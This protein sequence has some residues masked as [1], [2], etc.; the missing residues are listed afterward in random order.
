MFYQCVKCKKIWQYPIEKCPDCFLELVKMPS[1]EI[2]VIGISKVSIPTFFHQKVPYF[3]LLLEDK[4]GNRWVQKSMKEYQID[5]DFTVKKAK[6]SD[7]VALFRV[8]YDIQE[9]IEKVL[10]SVEGIKINSETKILILPTLVKSAHPYQAFNTNPQFLDG[11]LQVL[12]ARGAAS[13]NIRVAGQGFENLPIEVLAKKSKMLEVCLYNKISVL[14]LEKT[15][16]KRV[17][18]DHFIFDISE[19]VFNND[20]IIN[21]P[22]L[23]LD[24][25]IGVRGAMENM[26]RFLK[27]ESFFGL[28]YLYG[29]DI[30]IER[31]QEVL[32]KYLTI[33]DGIV[34][35]RSTGFNA[36]LNIVLGS[37]NSL[38][39]DRVFTEVCMVRKPPEFLERVKIEDISVVG[40]RIEEVQLN[41]ELF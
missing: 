4:N 7:A 15:K 41:A 28:K 11:L 29:E 34:I 6:N 17:E 37:F 30:L 36:F 23:K 1:K 26:V 8:K 20:L 3:V 24:F 40:R 25:Q 27:R 39:L 9:G 18:K 33:A 13:K 32:P 14:N 5:D 38:N 16:F 21:L 10:N 12:F 35:Q 19:E 22:I 2:K 31:L